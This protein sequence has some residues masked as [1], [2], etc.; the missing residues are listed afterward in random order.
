ML[1]CVAVVV[2]ASV[3][4]NVAEAIEH[5]NKAIKIDSGFVFALFNLGQAHDRLGNVRFLPSR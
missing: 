5:Y 1:L 4:G 3:Q 2:A